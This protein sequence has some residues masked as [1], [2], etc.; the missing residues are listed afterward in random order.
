MSRLSKKVPAAFALCGLLLMLIGARVQAQPKTSGAYIG[1][2]YPAGGRQGTTVQ[3]R[4]GGQRMDGAYGAIVSGEGVHAEIVDYL[5]DHTLSLDF[6]D[7]AAPPLHY[8]FGQLSDAQARRVLDTLGY[9]PLFDFNWVNPQEHGTIDGIPYTKRWDIPW[10]AELTKVVFIDVDGWNDKYIRI[11]AEGE[12]YIKDNILRTV[13]QGE[14]G[15]VWY[16]RVGEYRDTARVSYDQDKSY[17]TYQSGQ[18]TDKGYWLYDWEKTDYDNSP[19]PLYSSGRRG[20]KVI[21]ILDGFKRIMEGR[22]DRVLEL[23]AAMLAGIHLRGGS[24]LHTNRANPT[25]RAEHLETCVRTLDRLGVDHRGQR[26]LRGADVPRVLR[27]GADRL[28]GQ[29][30]RHRGPAHRRQLGLRVGLLVGGL[31]EG[32]AVLRHLG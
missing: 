24:I 1:Y 26:G 5:G 17:H 28:A 27:A 16:E 29:A 7:L 11:P 4:I 8:T 9:K 19:A 20:A 14:G 25:K 31:S 10:A 6:T 12:Q 23:D 3:V 30:V 22:T 15:E 2:V 18:G 32:V 13:S 21:G